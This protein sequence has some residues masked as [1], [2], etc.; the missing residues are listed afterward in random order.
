MG[1]KEDLEALGFPWKHDKCPACGST[2]RACNEVK[3]VLLKHK[4]V[5]DNANFGIGQYQAAIADPAIEVL[6]TP[7]LNA[8]IDICECGCVW[9]PVVNCVETPLVPVAQAGGNTHGRRQPPGFGRG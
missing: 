9:S 6:S 3:L 1:Q 5:R 7:I 8:V 4:K 2:R